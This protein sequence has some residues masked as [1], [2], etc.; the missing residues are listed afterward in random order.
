MGRARRV[1][2][3]PDS[4]K[5]TLTSVDLAAALAAGWRR[6]RPGDAVR[7]MPLG[8]GGAGTLEALAAAGG[9]T[10]REAAARDPLGRPVRAAWLLRADGTAAF[11]ELA[12][13]SGLALVAPAER[14]PAAASTAGTGD[15]LRAVLDAGVRSVVLGLGGSAT[16][17][18]GAGL[19]AALGARVGPDLGTVDLAG[20]DPR[21]AD[22]DLRIAC[23]VTN[24]LLGP[25]GAAA[26]YGPQKGA[27]R[28]AVAALDARLGRWADALEAATGRAARDVPG[29]GAAGGTAF[30]LLAV[31]DRLAGC[32][33]EPGAGLVMRAAGFDDALAAADLVV[34]GEGRIDAQTGW[35]KT[36]FAVATRARERGVPCLAVGGG[37]TPEGAAVL[38]AAGAVAVPAVDEPVPLDAALALGAA[39]FA[40]CAER[41]ARI[42]SLGED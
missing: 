24:P 39:P 41:L 42:L 10:H 9:W 37:V 40:S 3:A 38:A 2:V 5:G 11:V 21:L 33:L 35:G 27:D 18:G 16:T 14:D 32:V 34:T 4:A 7:A 6:G 15:V 1:L 8:D 26:T 30:A 17:D 20:L 25:A 31:T 19:L 28:A 13:A 36:A 12:A 22:L 29:A 23:D